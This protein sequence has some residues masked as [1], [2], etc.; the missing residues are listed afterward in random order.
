MTSCRNEPASL[1][2]PISKNIIDKIG[3]LFDL[4]FKQCFFLYNFYLQY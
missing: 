4:K 3:K 1:I 2:E